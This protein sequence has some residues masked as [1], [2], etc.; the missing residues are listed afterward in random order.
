MCYYKKISIAAIV[1]EKCSKA[2]LST[3]LVEL[4]SLI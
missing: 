2:Q 1:R 4:I 3:I